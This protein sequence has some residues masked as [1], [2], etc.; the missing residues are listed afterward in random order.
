MGQRLNLEIRSGGK[1]IA[2][3]YYHWSAYTGSA[4][5]IT[6]DAFEYLSKHKDIIS[7]KKV[8]A[9]RALEATGAGLPDSEVFRMHEI[10]K[11]SKMTFQ[12]FKDRNEGIIGVF[13]DSIKDTQ[14]WSEG[15]SI[16]DL[17]TMTIS[18]SVLSWYEDMDEW[19]D[20]YGE[21]TNPEDIVTLEFDPLGSLTAEQL[22]KLVDLVSNKWVDYNGTRFCDIA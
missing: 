3:S 9:I 2:N 21:D 12:E 8:L 13:P 17:D 19:N 22:K 4:Y 6:M 11:Y 20:Y 15:D 5:V 10:R 18:F 16:I 7:D 14:V 1:V